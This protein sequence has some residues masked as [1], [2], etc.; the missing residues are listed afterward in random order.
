MVRLFD[1]S[2]SLLAI[3]LLSPLCLIIM[4]ILIFT[5][6]GKIW[7]TQKRIGK[8]LKFFNLL[9]FATMLENSSAIGTKSL[10]IK[11]DPRILPFGHFLR[12]SKI[13]ELPQLIN[14]LKGDMSLIGPRP[15]TNEAFMRY[16][17]DSQ[18]KISEMKP[19]L[20]GIGSIYFR[21]E[22]DLLDKNVDPIEYY[23]EFIAPAKAE[24]EIWFSKNNTLKNYFKMI[25]AT[26]LVII[27]PN[28]DILKLFF[29]DLPNIKLN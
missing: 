2:L 28:L 7:Y 18:T 22:E 11:N 12:K 14:I 1:F 21:N 4:T 8:N 9:K 23:I 13:N 6:E 26:I 5:G 24:L 19:G 27:F 20:S 17:K 15:L 25:L 16:T 3:I 10:T 29:K